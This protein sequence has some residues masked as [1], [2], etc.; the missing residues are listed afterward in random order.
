MTARRLF[1]ARG[2]GWT[3]YADQVPR[4]YPPKM[5]EILCAGF[6]LGAPR[7]L[8]LV[9]GFRVSAAHGH[10]W[11]GKTRGRGPNGAWMLCI[12][13]QWYGTRGAHKRIRIA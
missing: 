6:P 4:E 13:G 11:T 10:R 3:V 8:V 2:L 5:F 7:A 12:C 1:A 9:N